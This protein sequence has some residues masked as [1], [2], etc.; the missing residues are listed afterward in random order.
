MDLLPAFTAYLESLTGTAALRSLSIRNYTSILRVYL[1]AKNPPDDEAR[2]AG[3]LTTRASKATNGSAAPW[4]AAF[5]HWLRFRN[6]DPATATLHGRREESNLR[7]TLESTELA[8]FNDAV[9]GIEHPAVR[10]LLMLLPFTGQR[11]HEICKLQVSEYVTRGGTGGLRF[12]GKRGKER[13]VPLSTKA[14]AMLDAHIAATTPTRW[15]FPALADPSGPMRADTVRKLLRQVR[16]SDTWTP[17]VLRHTFATRSLDKGGNLAEVQVML[18][19]KDI[20]TTA[21]YLHPTVGA[22]QRNVNRLDEP[23]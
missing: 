16:E 11:I 22:L 7:D 2:I 23:D 3:Y 6:L 12:V 15:I 17:H 10:C 4:R 19:H 18:G 20:E 13:F 21:I 1:A 5:K 9:Q 8:A 14:R